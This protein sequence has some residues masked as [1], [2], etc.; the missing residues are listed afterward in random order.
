MTEAIKLAAVGIICAVIIVLVRQMRPEFAPFVQAG[1]VIVITVMLAEYLKIILEKSTE[2]FESFEIFDAAY[3]SLL[4][5]VLGIAIVTK[6]GADI[7]ADNGNAALQSVVELAGKVLILAMCL[8][9][10]ETVVELAGG[11]LK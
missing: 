2:I 4:V 3:L 8:P 6:I 9:L 1:G 7:C 10:I 5:K 11:L